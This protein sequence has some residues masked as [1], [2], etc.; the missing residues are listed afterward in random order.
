M[1]VCFR[2]LRDWWW[3]G[4]FEK[5]RHSR[6]FWNIGHRKKIFLAH[7]TGS[8]V[9]YWLNQLKQRTNCKP[10]IN[11]KSQEN[12]RIHFSENKISAPHCWTALSKNLLIIPPG[13]SVHCRTST[14]LPGLFMKLIWQNDKLSIH[15]PYRRSERRRHE[16]IFAESFYATQLRVQTM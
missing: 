15:G 11:A 14:T 7:L 9:S 4:N 1:Q 5:T 10:V 6:L 12:D 2:L 13:S 8:V 16:N 3:Y